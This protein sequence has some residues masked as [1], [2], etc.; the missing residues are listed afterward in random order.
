MWTCTKD[1]G[2]CH[3]ELVRLKYYTQ[4]EEE[5]LSEVDLSIGPAKE[6]V[7]RILVHLHIGAQMAQLST[8]PAPPSSQRSKYALH[9]P[10]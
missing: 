9:K 1:C 7:R 6:G 8:V 3:A 4:N 2:N 5:D 10:P